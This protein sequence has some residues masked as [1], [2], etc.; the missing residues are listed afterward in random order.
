MEQ[1]PFLKVNS[2]FYPPWDGKW[3]SAFGLS[4]NNKW[5]WRLESIAA[6]RRTRS[7]S[8][9]AWSEGR[10]P[11]GAVLHSS[12]EPSELDLTM[13]LWSWWQHY[14]Y[15]PGYYYYYS[16]NWEG[17]TTKRVFT[18]SDN[19]FSRDSLPS[20]YVPIYVVLGYHFKLLA[21]QNLLL[22]W[23]FLWSFSICRLCRSKL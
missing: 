9:V 11:L 3:V 23:I 19:Q 4:N 22:W 12:N 16:P 7:P 5:R 18:Y 17:N 6:Y 10:R 21:I 14:K 13:T 15:C 1:W 2:A 8:Q 20:S